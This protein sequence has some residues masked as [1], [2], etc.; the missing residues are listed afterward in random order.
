MAFFNIGC[1]DHCVCLGVALLVMFG[2][3]GL[4]MF[5][6]AGL[7]GD[8]VANLFRNLPVLDMTLG[9]VVN[10]A[11]F[12]RNLSSDLVALLLRSAIGN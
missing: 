6:V 7:L 2:V 12:I 10:G 9:K 8:G 3:T 4:V 5:G 1:V 11:V